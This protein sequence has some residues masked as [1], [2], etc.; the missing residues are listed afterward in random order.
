[1]WTCDTRLVNCFKCYV[2]MGLGDRHRNSS[3]I[4][5]H[6]FRLWLCAVRQQAMAWDH[7]HPDICHKDIFLQNISGISLIYMDMRNMHFNFFNN[8][9]ISVLKEYLNYHSTYRGHVN[10]HSISTFIKSEMDD[11]NRVE[12]LFLQPGRTGYLWS[13]YIISRDVSYE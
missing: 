3:V 2:V 8:G 11:D 1:M 12:H 13:R 6:C 5:Q 9:S 4:N 7:V 10:E